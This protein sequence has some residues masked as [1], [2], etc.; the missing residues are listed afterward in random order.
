MPR[1]LPQERDGV[2]DFYAQL[3]DLCLLLAGVYMLY[4]AVTGKGSLY[5]ADNVKEEKKE[6]YGRFIR[7]F[8]AVAGAAAV[9]TVALDYFK[10]EPYA[11]ILYGILCG[12]IV[13]FFAA[14]FVFNDRK[15]A[16]RK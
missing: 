15:K 4:C 6:S 10:L 12:L 13:V 8:C 14:V 1:N 5:K 7:Y 11:T 3:I 16:P 9:A 2:V